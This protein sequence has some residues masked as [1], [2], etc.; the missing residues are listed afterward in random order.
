MRREASPLL[1][2]VPCFP[3]AQIGDQGLG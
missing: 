3:P 2:V 1:V